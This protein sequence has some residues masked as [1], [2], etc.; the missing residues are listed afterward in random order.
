M[1]TSFLTASSKTL[2]L[3]ECERQ[4]M[5]QSQGCSPA[6]SDALDD[7][8]GHAISQLVCEAHW[9]INKGSTLLPNK[10][11]IKD[12]YSRSEAQRNEIYLKRLLNSS[13]RSFLWIR[14]TSKLSVSMYPVFSFISFQTVWVKK[15]IHEERCDRSNMYCDTKH[16]TTNPHL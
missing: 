2:I 3:M 1:H 12:Y 16:T 13:Q 7:D 6:W 8:D 11:E 14:H 4:I 15:D 10:T 9:S 5:C